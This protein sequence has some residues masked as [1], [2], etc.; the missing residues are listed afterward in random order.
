MFK[1]LSYQ[2]FLAIPS[3]VHPSNHQSMFTEQCWDM[4]SA[5][6]RTPVDMGTVWHRPSLSLDTTG[7]WKLTGH[8]RNSSWSSQWLLWDQ[9][10]C[11]LVTTI[12]A[13]LDLG[14]WIVISPLQLVKISRDHKP[15]VLN[16]FCWCLGL[17]EPC[18]TSDTK[19]QLL[20]R[21][22]EA[23]QTLRALLGTPNPLK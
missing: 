12:C 23:P 7:W 6:W 2:S 4:G 17:T 10:T 9:H 18:S 22:Y 1:Q 21:P 15:S 14:I 20:R 3:L 8:W 16:S 13:T 5:P 19:P 11:S